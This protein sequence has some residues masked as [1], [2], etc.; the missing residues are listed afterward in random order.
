MYA[1]IWF[2]LIV[3]VGWSIGNTAGYHQHAQILGADPSALEIILGIVG[4]TVGC[5]L[6][7]NRSST[8]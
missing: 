1:V 2:V 8:R 5:H 3:V 6:F 7:L 4:A